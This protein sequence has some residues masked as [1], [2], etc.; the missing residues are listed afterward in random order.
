MSLRDCKN[1]SNETGAKEQFQDVLI[2]H[3]RQSM[4]QQIGG[5]VVLL[6]SCTIAR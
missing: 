3:A 6:D 2:G 4:T 1:V 5:G